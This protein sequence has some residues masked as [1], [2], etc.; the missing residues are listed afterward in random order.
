VLGLPIK[1]L[2]SPEQTLTSRGHHHTLTIW[3]A[4]VFTNY[5]SIKKHLDSIPQEA[6]Q[7]VTVDLHHARYIDHTVMENLHNYEPNFQL[8]GGEFHVINLDEHK[9]MSAHPLA[10]R[11]KRVMT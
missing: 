4:A 9:P 1:Y 2:F 10:A 8:A 5:L 6:G 3:G 7:F 11:R